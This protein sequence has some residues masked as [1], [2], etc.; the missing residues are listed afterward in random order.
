MKTVTC[1]SKTY[2][3]Y[4]DEVDF[5]RTNAYKL[6]SIYYDRI[7]NADRQIFAADFVSDECK[8]MFVYNDHA[9]DL[10]LIENFSF[11]TKLICRIVNGF[12]DDDYEALFIENVSDDFKSWLYEI[13]TIG[14]E[15]PNLE[16]QFDLNIEQF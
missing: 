2:Q 3:N 15:D 7:Y 8:L 12:D 16:E 5:K 11:E 9:F 13:S 4:A 14:F 1:C 6:F 10:Y